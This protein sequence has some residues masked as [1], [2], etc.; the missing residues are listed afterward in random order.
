MAMDGTGSFQRTCS[1]SERSRERGH[2]DDT[3]CEQW[4]CTGRVCGRL[5]GGVSFLLAPCLLHQCARLVIR[6]MKGVVSGESLTK[7]SGDQGS[8]TPGSRL[9]GILSPAYVLFAHQ[10]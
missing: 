2:P 8:V 10:I 4:F 5:W 3:R 1:R 7:G 6:V 9:F